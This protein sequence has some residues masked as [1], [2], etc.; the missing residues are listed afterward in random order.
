MKVRIE[1]GLSLGLELVGLQVL[2][3]LNE[4]ASDSTRKLTVHDG[5]SY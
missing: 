1:L 5:H 2:L 4:W 3:V